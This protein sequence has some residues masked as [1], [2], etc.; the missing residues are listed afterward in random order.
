MSWWGEQKAAENLEI[1]PPI[2]REAELREELRQVE[3][4]L[5]QL[6]DEMRAFRGEHHLRTDRFNQITGMLSAS[7]NGRASVEREW[8]GYCAG[9]NHLLTRHNALLRELALLT[10]PG[11]VEEATR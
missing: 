1:E 3:V 7:M 5:R 4:S 8:R 10:V 2:D 11:F 9:V 6:N